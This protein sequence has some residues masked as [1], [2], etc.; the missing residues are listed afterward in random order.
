MLKISPLPRFDPRTVE[1]VASR[2]TDCAILAISKVYVKR[3]TMLDFLMNYSEVSWQTL[4]ED[5]YALWLDPAWQK[6]QPTLP[7][8]CVLAKQLTV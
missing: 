1:L 7:S 3:D 6:M 8:T 4:R 2:Y 5:N